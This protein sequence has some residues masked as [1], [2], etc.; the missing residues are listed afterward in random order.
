MDLHTAATLDDIL[1][2]LP[3]VKGDDAVYEYLRNAVDLLAEE[4]RSVG[5]ISRLS[6]LTNVLYTAVGLFV[7]A[8]PALSRAEAL[9]L[10][11]D[12]LQH[13]HAQEQEPPEH[14]R[15]SLPAAKQRTVTKILQRIRARRALAKPATPTGR[16]YVMVRR[17]P[18][19]LE[20]PLGT[21]R[22]YRMEELDQ[23][24][25]MV[26]IGPDG[27]HGWLIDRALPAP[28]FLTFRLEHPTGEKVTLETALAHWAKH[29]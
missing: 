29:Y 3:K 24:K 9:R 7:G 17:H 15:G 5:Q 22:V 11:A 12:N 14:A 8:T 4:D 20:Q 19:G 1:T 23:G 18:L 10:L 27:K 2:G 26:G 28:S 13:R 25:V 21:R 6:V 16:V